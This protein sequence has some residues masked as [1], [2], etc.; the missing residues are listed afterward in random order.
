MIYII[1]CFHALQFDIP[2]SNY[3]MTELT[4]ARKRYESLVGKTISRKRI[5]LLAEELSQ[6][7]LTSLRAESILRRISEKIDI[8]HR[9]CDPGVAE[10]REL[11][12]PS[13][14]EQSDEDDDQLKKNHTIREKYWLG[15]ISDCLM[16]PIIFVCGSDHIEGFTS[17]LNSRGI[18]NTVIHVFDEEPVLLD[19]RASD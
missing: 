11:G 19:R 5:R 13:P 10:R 1:G 9:F 16:L 12:L 15:E 14:Y 18:R 3:D 17:I 4:A 8:E 7:I 6:E 2:R